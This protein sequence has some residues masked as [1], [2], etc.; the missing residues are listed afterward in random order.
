MWRELHRT[1][2]GMIVVC[3][4]LVLLA[5]ANDAIFLIR[6]NN[7]RLAWGLEVFFQDLLLKLQ[8]ISG[9]STT[10]KSPRLI[11]QLFCFDQVSR[12]VNGYRAGLDERYGLELRGGLHQ[13]AFIVVA[14]WLRFL[15]LGDR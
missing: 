10:H 7:F 3:N 2:R 1:L 15:T 14:R 12:T 6:L 13:A 5:F 9:R 11:G 8:P 4:C